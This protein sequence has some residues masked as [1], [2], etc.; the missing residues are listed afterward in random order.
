[1]MMIDVLKINVLLNLQ[2]V[3]HNQV[4]VMYAAISIAKDALVA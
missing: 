1:M 2:K 3:D 4:I